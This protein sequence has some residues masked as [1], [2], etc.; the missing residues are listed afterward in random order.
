MFFKK[1]EVFLVACELIGILY[2]I[3]H[4]RLGPGYSCLSIH[5]RVPGKLTA[6]L[7]E[8][9]YERV[10]CQ[11]GIIVGETVFCIL[12][13]V[14]AFVF[15]AAYAESRNAYRDCGCKEYC[16]LFHNVIFH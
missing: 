4:C 8:C 14:A 7:E 6:V 5:I 15:T 2:H 3:E 1:I 12:V 13:S 9:G 11:H 16:Y 10:E